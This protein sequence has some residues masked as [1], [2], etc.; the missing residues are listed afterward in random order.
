M[1]AARGGW[2]MEDWPWNL[3]PRGQT[4]VGWGWE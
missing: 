4:P 3:A 2:R 1:G